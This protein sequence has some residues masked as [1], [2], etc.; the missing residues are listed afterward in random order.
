M[1]WLLS[2]FLNA[3]AVLDLNNNFSLFDEWHEEEH[4]GQ[5][6]LE[7]TQ[8]HRNIFKTTIFIL[9]GAFCVGCCDT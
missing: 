4:K 3:V 1:W 8:R 2:E 7:G 6:L 5:L 9:Y